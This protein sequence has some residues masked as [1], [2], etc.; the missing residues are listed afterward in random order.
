M[1]HSFSVFISAVTREF[2]AA[3]DALANA[4]QARKLDVEVQRSFDLSDGT[5]LGKL[6]DDIRRCDRVIAVIGAYSG[7]FPPEGAVTEEFRKML[8][9][10]MSRA[11]LTQW[12][13]IFALHYRRQVYFFEANGFDAEDKA[14]I[15]R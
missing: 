6:H 3:R 14:A 10:G 8:P 5:T 15:G 11:S 9:A 7:L 2:G 4:F 1:G 13:V 12:E